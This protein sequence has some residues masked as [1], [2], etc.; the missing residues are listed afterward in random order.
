MLVTLPQL[1]YDS[2]AIHRL[3][4][5]FPTLSLDM[6]YRGTL[7]EL[8]EILLRHADSVADTGAEG[9]ACHDANGA[10]AIEYLEIMAGRAAAVGGYGLVCRKARISHARAG[11]RT[12]LPAPARP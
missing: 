2:I 1:G 9:T 3:R 12:G 5:E 11:K 6:L 4:T 7:A 10:I 8:D